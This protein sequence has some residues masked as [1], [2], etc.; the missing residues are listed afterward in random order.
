VLFYGIF[1]ILIFDPVIAIFLSLFIIGAI[2]NLLSSYEK[3][4]SRKMKL[5]LTFFIF[6]FNI[7]I[8]GFSFIESNID[9][10]Y[11]YLVVPVIFCLLLYGPLYY[12][13]K[14]DVIKQKVLALYSY[15]SSWVLL[16]LIFILNFFIINLYFSANIILGT[17]LNFL[18]FTLC[19]VLL[20]LFGK[21]IKRVKE[22]SSKFILNL[23]SYPIIIE[24]FI[25]LFTI[26]TNYFQ[27][28]V[29]L[30]SFLSLAIIS[31]IFQISSKEEKLFPKFPAMILN[32]ITLY[33]GVFIAGY[34]S[35]IFTLGT[36]YIYSI[37]LI[38]VCIL[39]YLPIYYLSKKTVLNRITFLKYHLVCSTII[40]L[41]IFSLNFFII[42]HFF[43]NYILILLILFNILYMTVVSYYIFKFGTK[44]NLL[45]AG[46]FKRYSLIVNIFTTLEIFAI[47][48][49]IFSQ[50]FQDPVLS[51][52]FSTVPICLII[53]ILSKNRIIFSEKSAIVINIITLSFTSVLSSFYVFLLTYGTALVFV[54]PLLVFSLMILLPLFYTTSKRVFSKLVAKILI[55]DSLLISALIMSLPAVLN[56]ELISL[57]FVMTYQK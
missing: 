32:T 36:F 35:V 41:A 43:N 57:V 12:L 23:L 9:Y 6:A 52:Y 40:S 31:V 26:F 18:F 11:F 5:T 24:F 46:S 34:Y 4:V 14:E 48:F 20:I 28:D 44:L 25:L 17:S 45:S 22:S 42:F 53:N 49:S 51:A 10:F 27:F 13:Y 7:C 2:F 15:I 37:P 56:L 47:L 38:I 3:L 33:F 8:I 55:I 16:V 54:I 1:N 29:F 19:L 39:S 30:S 50:V 21:K